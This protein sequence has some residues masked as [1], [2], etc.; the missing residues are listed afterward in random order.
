MANKVEYIYIYIYIYIILNILL[1]CLIIVLDVIDVIEIAYTF[2]YIDPCS[3]DMKVVVGWRRG[4]G[5]GH[6][7]ESNDELS[8]SINISVF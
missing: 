6:G 8:A 4:D 1:Q 5:R 3:S 7:K 2:I